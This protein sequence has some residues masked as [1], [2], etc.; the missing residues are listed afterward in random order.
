MT[1]RTWTLPA[2]A[3]L[4]LALVLTFATTATPA[5]AQEASWR[6]EQ[7]APPP[8][9]PGVS[10]SSLPIPLGTAGGIGYET[11]AIGDIEFWAPNRGL[12]IT[13]GNEPTIPPGIW[14]YNGVQWHEL[15]EV[16][17]AT[18]GS[19]AWAGPD[20]F[21]TVSDGRAGQAHVLAGS[22][23]A[24]PL[25]DNTLCHFAGGQLVASYAH[26]AFEADSY[27][28][29]HGAACLGPTD[30][31]FGG[32]PLPEPQIGAFH[33]HWNGSSLEA[34][35]YPD[36]GHAVEDMQA[37][38]GHLY[39]SVRVASGDHM[40][41]REQIEL[42][43]LHRIN[44][45]GVQPTFQPER[46][47]PLYGPDEL[48]EALGPLRL[49]A[50]EGAL[51][52]AAG[53]ENPEHGEPGQVT[54]VRRAGHSWSQLIGAEHP[55]DP[56]LP[57]DPAEEQELLGGEARMAPV[58]A[59]A[60]EPQTGDAWLALAPVKNST[61]FFSPDQRA[62]LVHLSPE[63][64]VLGEVTLPTADEQAD[65]I[66]PKG[67]AAKLTCPAANDCWLATTQGWLF[68][69]AP[70]DQRV[71]PRD[72]HESEYFT[73]LITYRPPDQGL[74]QV[75]P[76]APPIDDSGL[77]EEAPDYGGTFAETKGI[78]IESTILAPLLTDLH[79]RLVKGTTLELR[80]HLAVKARVR[81]LAER[82]KKVVASTP[83]RTFAAGARK[84]LLRLNRREWPTKLSLQ[85]HALAPLPA[86]TVKE[87][88]GGPEH[89]GSG[90]NTVST[91]LIVLPQLPTFAELG[92]R[93]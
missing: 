87:A 22:E 70:E 85:T 81:M 43:A 89:G 80:F 49:S 59:I 86:S 37:F 48:A 36:E 73:G 91:G 1:S 83:M 92:P 45:E 77:L 34:E 11:P 7:P 69:L 2:L 62:V 71:L 12:L 50:T 29:M 46:S 35:P 76:D 42:P 3:L 93:P 39:E 63:G 79:S 60:A 16:C 53:A 28:A 15:A 18:D 4:A 24:P 55:L 25:E 14:A 5:T 51:W 13:R 74:P 9:P 78:P 27:Q 33:L 47:L 8:P 57:A 65:G 26:P 19:I 31:W 41:N 68:H 66:G 72:E 67:A 30:C 23:E 17:G 54:V 90:S 64:A 32:D 6:L 40:V 21:W 44:P 58:S 75:P 20:E 88:V 56:I 82:R 52:A 10:G 61:A 84:L 38:E